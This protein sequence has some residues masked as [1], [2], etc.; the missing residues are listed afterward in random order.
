MNNGYFSAIQNLLSEVSEKNRWAMQ[1]CASILAECL[2]KEGIL[3]VFGC[4]HSHMIAEE[5]F[6]RAGGIVPIRPVLVEDVMLHKGALRSSKMERDPSFAETFLPLQPFQPN[7]VLLVISTSGR[8]PVPIDVA[9]YGIEVGM[10]V[11]TIS[12]HAYHSLISRHSTGMLLAET[13]TIAIDNCIP[14]GDALVSLKGL[15]TSIGPGSTIINAA[16]TNDMIVRTIELLHNRGLDVPI[17]RSGNID[18]AEEHN[19]LVM[20]KYRDRI[21][22]F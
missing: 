11:I 4:G 7:D 17:F 14:Q 15:Q 5:A 3:H 18:G 16:I 19:E 1:H 2:E 8:N 22:M 13:A 20:K 9:R 12:S 21:E 10:K 6:Y